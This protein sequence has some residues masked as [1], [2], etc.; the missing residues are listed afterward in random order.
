MEGKEE[1]QFRFQLRFQSRR[2]VNMKKE[3][4]FLKAN[5]N[6]LDQTIWALKTILNKDVFRIVTRCVAITV[7]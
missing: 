5:I 7:M 1:A 2:A 3:P 6:Q 4:L